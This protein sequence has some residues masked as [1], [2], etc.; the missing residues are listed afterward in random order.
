MKIIDQLSIAGVFIETISDHSPSSIL[1]YVK[2][3]TTLTTSIEDNQRF[4]LIS[5]QHFKNNQGQFATPP[6]HLQGS[7]FVNDPSVIKIE[8]KS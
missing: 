7:K 8:F 5:Q 1:F 3:S 4:N 6:W 2:L